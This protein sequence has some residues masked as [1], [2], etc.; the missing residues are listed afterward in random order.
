MFEQVSTEKVAFELT[1][2]GKGRKVFFSGSINNGRD[3]KVQRT[4]NAFHIT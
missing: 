1:L 4:D 2:E 3:T